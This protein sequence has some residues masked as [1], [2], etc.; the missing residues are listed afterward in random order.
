MQLS[1][2]VILDELPLTQNGKLDR[3][4]LPAP[5]GREGVGLYQAPEGLLEQKVAVIWQELLKIE[6]V[7]R[8]DNFFS[9]GGDSIISIQLVVRARRS[10]INFDVKQVFETP[11]VRGLAAN[12]RRAEID[13]IP[14]NLM[15]GYVPLLPIQSWFFERDLFDEN[16]YNQSMWFI[17]KEFLSEEGKSHLRQRLVNIYN[18]HDTLRLR[19]KKEGDSIVQYYDDSNPFCWEEIKLNTWN[20]VDKYCTKI[21][22]SLDI[23]N[24]P[25]SKLVWF[26]SNE[27][28]GLFWVIHHLL[29]DGVSWRILLDDLNSST[30]A[31]KSYSYQAF[32]E[33]AVNRKDLDE[34]IAYYQNKQV[35]PI[36]KDYELKGNEVI[37]QNHTSVSLSKQDSQDFIQKAHS[38]YNTQANDLLLTALVMSIGKHT[39]KYSLWVDLEGHGREGSLDVSRTLGWFTTVYPVHLHITNPSNLTSCI[40]EIK[41]QLRKIP[42][43]GFGYGI[44]ICQNKLLRI[45]SNVVFNYLGQWDSGEKPSSDFSYGYMPKGM[46]TSKKNKPSHAI[47]INGGIQRGYLKFSFSYTQEFHQESIESIANEFKH[48]LIALIKHCLNPDNYGYTPSDFTFSAL[49]DDDIECIIEDMDG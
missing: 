23:M 37:V 30:L 22:E 14:Q 49:S 25:L 20:E 43:K 29:V 4:A 48:F 1:Q 5:E 33:Y 17:P 7:G 35:V 27:K 6:K 32:A 12:S 42:E 46:S 13:S 39:G 21:H 18:H 26:E 11:T 19:Y 3:K 40:K 36:V 15:S 31:K 41:E 47:S 45:E 24:G 8:N 16:H 2:I 38:S 34:T 10:G 44:A 9:L 28:Q